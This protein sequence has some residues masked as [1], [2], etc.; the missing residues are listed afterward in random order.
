MDHERHTTSSL[1]LVATPPPDRKPPII[2]SAK[3]TGNPDHAS[4]AFKNLNALDHL[5]PM[6]KQYQIKTLATVEP[7]LEPRET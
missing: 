5:S 1:I 2:R 6:V 7:H 3:F 4:H